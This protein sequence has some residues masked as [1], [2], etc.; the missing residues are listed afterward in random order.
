MLSGAIALK[1]LKTPAVMAADFDGKVFKSPSCGCCAVWVKQ[2]KQAGI[3]LQITDFESL[4]VIK[5][6]FQVPEQLQ[7]CHTAIIDGYVVEGHVPIKE[8]KRLLNEK[9]KALGIAVPGMPLGSL[10]MEQGNVKEPY[11]VVIFQTGT[12]RVY[13]RY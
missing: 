1:A 12:Q 4:E 9:P 10:G 5:R 11:D 8:I 7:S 3:D 2:L 6:M 13:A